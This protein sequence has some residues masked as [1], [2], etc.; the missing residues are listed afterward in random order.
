MAA[1]CERRTT[2]TVRRRFGNQRPPP[3]GRSE[4]LSLGQRLS[5]RRPQT[6][7]VKNILLLNW[8]RRSETVA[9]FGR[10]T[11]HRHRDGRYE[12]RGGSAADR[13][14]ACEWASLFQHDAVF[15][16]EPAERSRT[17]IR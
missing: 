11:L 10:A 5:H 14:E 16:A 8:N 2:W 3:N 12:L 1:P 9:S 17:T 4:F 13:A 6:G 15:A 7:G